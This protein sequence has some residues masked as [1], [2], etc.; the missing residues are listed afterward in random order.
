MFQ[1][2]YR[3]AALSLSASATALHPA[4]A[5]LRC[6]DESFV[7]EHSPDE[8]LLDGDDTGDSGFRL[9]TLPSIH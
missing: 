6:G 5:V 3:F 4:S 8:L 9:T 7:S 2:T 1:Y